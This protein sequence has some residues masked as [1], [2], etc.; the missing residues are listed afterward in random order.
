VLKLLRGLNISTKYNRGYLIA[1]AIL[2]FAILP[3][4]SDP[5]TLRLLILT[6]MTLILCI[7]WNIIS[8]YTVFLSLGHS[9]FLGIG[10]YTSAILYEKYGISPWIGM[11]I[12]LAPSTLL[13]IIIGLL[14]FRL[15]GAFFALTTIAILQ[16][17]RL[18]ALHFADIT[19]GSLGIIYTPKNDPYNFFFLEVTPYYYVI[20]I[21]LLITIYISYRIDRGFLGKRLK[22]IG[23]DEI[24]S[25]SIGIDAMKSKLLAFIISALIATPVGTFYAQYIGYII[26]DSVFDLGLSIKVAVIGMIGG[27]GTFLGP[28]IGTFILIPIEQL[29]TIYLSSYYGLNLVIYGLLLMITMIFLPKGVISFIEGFLRWQKKY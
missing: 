5:G 2:F 3:L 14:T 27:A 25:V 23:D 26:P 29:L 10:A 15:H 12:S 20:Y 13:A 18:L 1:L 11:I 22:A 21:M 24:A 16:I 8:G 17:L 4:F 28:I 7:S 9:M 19:G 6:Y